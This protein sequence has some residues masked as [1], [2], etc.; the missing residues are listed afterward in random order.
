MIRPASLLGGAGVGASLMYL[1][2]PDRGRRR[3]AITRDKAKS[4]VRHG[5][6]ALSRA[7]RDLENRARGTV[8]VVRT[9]W[10]G[11][12]VGDDVLIARVRTQLGRVVSHPGAIEVGSEQGCITV[13]G[14]IL[15]R[16]VDAL[17]EAISKVPGVRE[18]RNELEAH[19]SA[20]RIPELQGSL[21]RRQRADDWSPAVRM[22][23]GVA[24]GAMAVYGFSRR[25]PLSI[26]AALIGTGLVTRAATNADIAGVLGIQRRG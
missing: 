26:G 15:K 7:A 6:D 20:D 16:E 23:A 19:S 18:I 24:G 21:S 10:S 25:D 8:S 13:S 1:L 17:I 3:R 12:S 9:K 11:D 22:I 14:T 2:D 5:G 4:V